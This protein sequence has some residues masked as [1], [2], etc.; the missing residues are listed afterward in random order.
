MAF[1]LSRCLHYHS[2]SYREYIYPATEWIDGF[3]RYTDDEMIEGTY[4]MISSTWVFIWY[5]SAWPTGSAS[6]VRVRQ[7]SNR[8]YDYLDLPSWTRIF[9]PLFMGLWT[10]LPQCEHVNHIS[11][12]CLVTLVLCTWPRERIYYLQRPMS[13]QRW[14]TVQTLV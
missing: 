4:L 7:V 14:P 2:L 12:R 3:H 1:H 5:F 6:G 8:H 9:A 11:I 13:S 10:V